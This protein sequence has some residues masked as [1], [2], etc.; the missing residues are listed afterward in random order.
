MRQ[1]YTRAGLDTE[2]SRAGLGPP[3]MTW[4]CR[5]VQQA[6]QNLQAVGWRLQPDQ[7]AELDRV[8]LKVSK[9]MIQNIFQTS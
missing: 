3:W 7:V 8:A 2:N 4:S 5:T 9:P 6:R 1:E